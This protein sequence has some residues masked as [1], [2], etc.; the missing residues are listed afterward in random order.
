MGS[1]GDTAV[2]LTTALD[3]DQ[4]KTYKIATDHPGG[5]KNWEN[6][7]NLKY[8]EQDLSARSLISRGK[9][10]PEYFQTQVD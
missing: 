5:A 1:E 7:P 4:S 8:F 10:N 9:G 3:K 2:K 6:D